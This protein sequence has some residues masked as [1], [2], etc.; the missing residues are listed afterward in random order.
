[1]LGLLFGCICQ[2]NGS[3]GVFVGIISLAY[4]LPSLVLGPLHSVLQGSLFEQGVKVLP[5]YYMADAFL[6]ALPNQATADNV[7]LD[8][9]VLAGSTAALF[10]ITLWGLRRQSAIAREI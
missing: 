3:V 10:C 9:L 8:M 6:K 1:M 4:T 2:T 5:P 7:L